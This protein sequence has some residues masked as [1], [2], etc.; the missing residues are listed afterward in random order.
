M[1]IEELN[2]SFYCDLKPFFM[3]GG[4]TFGEVIINRIATHCMLSLQLDCFY[5]Q[6]SIAL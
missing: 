5:S 2:V 1:D 6:T 4:F 3:L